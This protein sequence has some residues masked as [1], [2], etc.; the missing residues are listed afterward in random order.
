MNRRD[1]PEDREL[2]RREVAAIDNAQKSLQR[3]QSE[4]ARD[5]EQQTAADA[6][7]VTA[8]V[9]RHATSFGPIAAATAGL[10]AVTHA[11]SGPANP[12]S[13]AAD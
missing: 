7:M 10:E 8:A 4:C 12:I 6:A 3:L 2:Y 1:T 9:Q 11:P 5:L 13:L